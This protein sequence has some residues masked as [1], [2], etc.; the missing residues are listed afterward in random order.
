MLRRC[1]FNRRWRQWI[2]MCISTTRFSILVNGTPCG[3]F[4]SSRGLRQGDPLSPLLFIIVMEA[5]SRLL[6]RAHDGGYISRFDVGRV[7]HISISH[8]LFADD[9]L[10][11]CGAARDQLCHLKS[12]FVWFQ[13]SSG[14]KIN[15]GKSELV[16]VGSVPDVEELAVVLG[17]KVGTLPMSY[18]GLPLG[19]LFK[20]KTIWNG[21][22]EKL[23]LRLAGWKRMYARE[24]EALWRKIVDLKYGGLWGGWCSNSVLDPYGKS[25]WKHIRKGWP[26]FAKN[27]SFKVGDGTHIKFWQHQ[28][29]GETTLKSRF[30]ELYQLDWELESV[31]EFLDVIYTVVPTQGALDIIHWKH[32]SQKEFSVS[33]FYKCPLSPAKRDFP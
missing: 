28:W 24:K 9:T 18:L 29:C 17:C 23:E 16:P 31:A 27:V 11:L 5:L 10:I 7:N 1:G 19:S 25:L 8:L 12:V 21:I 33:S 26:T 13:A 14:L 22:V 20:D 2:Y 4:A 30:P 15:L 6:A 3:F 32:S